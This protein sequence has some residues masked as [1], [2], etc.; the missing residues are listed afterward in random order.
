MIQRKHKQEPRCPFFRDM[1]SHERTNVVLLIKV[2]RKEQAE[3]RSEN[4]VVS[5]VPL[6][7][8]VQ[9]NRRGNH[10]TQAPKRNQGM[11]WLV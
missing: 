11:K 6:G 2:F 7:C 1:P 8:T 10:K 3:E 9:A 4:E 5:V